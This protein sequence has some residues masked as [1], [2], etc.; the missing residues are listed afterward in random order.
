[1]KEKCCQANS[2]QESMFGTTLVA[3]CCGSWVLNITPLSRENDFFRRSPACQIVSQGFA[4]F[5]PHVECQ[6]IR[7]TG[8]MV[9]QSVRL[10]SELRSAV[11]QPYNMGM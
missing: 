5:L 1:M 3:L 4:S 10:K 8:N 2:A 6:C 9:L 7:H 11:Y